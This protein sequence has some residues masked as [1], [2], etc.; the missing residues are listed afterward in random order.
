MNNVHVSK[1][2]MQAAKEI[3]AKKND[4]I[5][6]DWKGLINGEIL[7]LLERESDD[8][9][10]VSAWKNDYKSAII[11]VNLREFNPELEAEDPEAVIKQITDLL[12]ADLLVE[13]VDEVELISRDGDFASWKAEVELG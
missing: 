8:K 12:E 4:Y 6:V 3:S 7:P 9:K 11:E 2:L 1:E 13:Y 10:A 5:Y